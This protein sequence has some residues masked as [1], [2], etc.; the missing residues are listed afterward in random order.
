[1]LEIV[2]WIDCDMSHRMVEL[3]AC[4]QQGGHAVAL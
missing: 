1:M 2:G 4:V 3:L